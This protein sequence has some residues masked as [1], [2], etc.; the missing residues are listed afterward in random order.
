MINIPTQ[1]YIE[2]TN[3]NVGTTHD[4]KA[5][6]THLFI[7]GSVCLLLYYISSLI[8]AQNTETQQS[9]RGMVQFSLY[10]LM[11]DGVPILSRL[12]I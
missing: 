11:E 12:F 8:L 3:E 6:C 5:S 1:K 10:I 7:E 4:W 9:Q 2:W